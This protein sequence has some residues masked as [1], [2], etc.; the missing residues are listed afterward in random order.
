MPGGPTLG[1]QPAATGD[2]GARLVNPEEAEAFRSACPGPPR[3]KKAMIKRHDFSRL[4][5]G[6]VI[7]SAQ[8]VARPGPAALT[9]VE[10]DPYLEHP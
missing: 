3:R 8:L 1:A 9:S 7:T 5:S 2:L 4:Q 10:T 6:G